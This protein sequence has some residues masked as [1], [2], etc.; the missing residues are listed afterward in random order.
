MKPSLA[1]AKLGEIAKL[2]RSVLVLEN[3]KRTDATK[4]FLGAQDMAS[5]VLRIVRR[6]GAQP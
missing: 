2:C 4:E 6:K 3:V 1:A 5:A